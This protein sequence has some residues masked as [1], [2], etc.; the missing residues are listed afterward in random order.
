[1][2]V[3]VNMAVVMVDVTINFQLNVRWGIRKMIR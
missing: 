1:M 3:M 2:K